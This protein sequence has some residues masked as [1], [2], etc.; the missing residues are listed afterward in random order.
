MYFS[1]FL[2]SVWFNLFYMF[3][4]FYLII[5]FAELCPCMIILILTSHGQHCQ[6]VHQSKPLAY[7]IKEEDTKNVVIK[8]LIE[9]RDQ[10][11]ID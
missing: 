7:P 5:Q 11:K 1:G 3:Y 10:T 6:Q 8:S 9:R 2:E 4:N